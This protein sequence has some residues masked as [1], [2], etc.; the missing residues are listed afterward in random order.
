MAVNLT[1]EASKRLARVFKAPDRA[2]EISVANDDDL[3]AADEVLGA[4]KGLVAEVD[5]TFDPIIK[6]NHAAWKEALAQKKRHMDPLQQAERMVKSEVAKYMEAKEA[7]R[8]RAEEE[9]KRQLAA[10]AEAEEAKLNAALEAEEAGD[11]AKADELLSEVEDQPPAPD[12]PEKTKLAHSHTVRKPKW[13]IVDAT[14]LPREYLM[15][16]TTKIGKI[17]RA[18]GEETSI[19]GVRVW[20]ETTVVTRR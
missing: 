9:R 7:E 18:L 2:A 6:R 14:K 19:P 12:V 5:D 3:R 17:V 10:Q 8:R 16:D 1:T 20:M 13:E 11:S 4:I 15:P